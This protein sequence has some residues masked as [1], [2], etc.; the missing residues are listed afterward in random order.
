MLDGIAVAW[1][2]LNVRN[3]T[4]GTVTVNV[5]GSVSMLVVVTGV[6]NV[7]TFVCVEVKITVFVRLIAVLF[8]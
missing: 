3:V 4:A 8:V 2:L 5:I 6:L 7:S 1:R